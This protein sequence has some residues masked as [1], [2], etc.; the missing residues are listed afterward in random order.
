MN[1]RK[2]AA[3]AAGALVAAG[4]AVAVGVSNAD[5]MDTTAATADT[6]YGQASTSERGSND[7]AV[8]GDEATKVGAAVTVKD[9]AVT[10]TSVRKDP[11][12]SYDV[13]GTK[14]GANVM[15]DVSADLATLTQNSK[16]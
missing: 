2:T 7:T 16:S 9:S 13:L 8:T 10:V 6:G 4:A 14:A 11:D 15:F 5:A 3:G 1:L 12:G